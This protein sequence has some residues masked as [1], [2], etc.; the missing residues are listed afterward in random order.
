MQR[1]EKDGGGVS[2]DS[3]DDEHG[4]PI[5]FLIVTAGGPHSRVRMW[6]LPTL[7]RVRLPQDVALRLDC[8]YHSLARVR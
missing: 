6:A 1:V 4:V 2:T 7:S 5:A 3:V 8:G